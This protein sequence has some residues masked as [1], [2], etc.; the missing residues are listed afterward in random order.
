MN[1]WA[2]RSSRHSEKARIFLGNE[3]RSGRPRQVH[4]VRSRLG[5]GQAQLSGLQVHVLPPERQDFGLTAPRQHEQPN[6]SDRRDRLQLL[7]VAFLQR[8]SEP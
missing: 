4:H 6:R 8:R 7:R 1:C 2:T 3:L 5:V